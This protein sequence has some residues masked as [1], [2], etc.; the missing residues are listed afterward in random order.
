MT[1]DNITES[2]LSDISLMLKALADQTR[3]KI[4][5]SLHEGE[6]CVRDII[7]DV[8]S[9]QANISK[10]LQIL[11]RSHLL[12]SRKEGTTVYYRLSDPCVADICRAVC[13]SYARLIQKKYQSLRGSR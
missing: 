10:H 7:E 8:G 5:K 6:K 12:S 3:L 4:M 13:S 1:L 11:S 2:E 9:G